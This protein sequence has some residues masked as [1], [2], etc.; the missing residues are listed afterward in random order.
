MI[1][2]LNGI[3]HV[4]IYVRDTKQA[5]AWYKEI[6]GFTVSQAYE[7]WAEDANGPLTIEDASGTIHLALFARS[8]FEPSTAI[9][10]NTNGAE[11]LKW[12]AYLDDKHLIKKCSDHDVSWSLYFHDPDNNMHEITSYDYRYITQALSLADE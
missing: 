3:D 2:K 11:F 4:H 8:V 1:P 12:K 6:L 7:F 9:A 10:F 5:A